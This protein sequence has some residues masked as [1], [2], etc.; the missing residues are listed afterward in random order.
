MSTFIETIEI[1]ASAERVWDTLADVGT[2]ADWNPSLLGSHATNEANG[3]GAT[4]YC[5]ID[6][7]QDLDEEVVRFEPMRAITFRITRST[8]PFRSADIRF[9][10][11]KQAE[12]TIVSVSPIYELKY[13]FVGRVLDRAF[14][15]ATYKRGMR[16][17]LKGLK[18]RVERVESDE[19]ELVS[20]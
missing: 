5:D 11:K 9:T 19:S 16:D 20:V 13:G 8:L 2:I 14:V 18:T 7:K 17:L 10:L 15:S 4:R 1:H 3:L 6:G 12:T